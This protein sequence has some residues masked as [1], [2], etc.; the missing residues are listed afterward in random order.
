MGIPPR[1][2]RR[3]FRASLHSR[4]LDAT[5]R[6]RAGT[7]DLSVAAVRRNAS[8]NGERGRHTSA[9]VRNGTGA[10]NGRISSCARAILDRER[11]LGEERDRVAPRDHLH[12]GREARRAEVHLVRARLPA[13]RERLRAQAVSVLEEEDVLDRR[14]RS[15]RSSSSSRADVPSAARRRTGRAGP[16]RAR[17]R[18]GRPRAR[19]APRR[20][21]RPRDRGRCPPSSPRGRR[22]GGAGYASART[23]VTSGRKYGSDRR[24][25]PD[26]ERAGERI[27]RARGHGEQVLGLDEDAPRAR[28]HLL[29]RRGQEDALPVALEELHPEHPLELLDLPAQRGLG[30]RTTLGRAPESQGIG[31]GHHVLELAQREVASGGATDSHHLS[32]A[33]NI[34]IGSISVEG[35]S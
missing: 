12:E 35:A 22:G 8:A 34:R 23:C 10:E 30:H 21:C 27:A 20:A 5:T 14:G 2:R 4:G 25:D 29:A 31:H 18:R 33:S 28:H 6:E 32:I 13:H 3:G 24:D 9:I 15:G 11:E 1:R 17:A 19:R 16:R 7:G 26:A